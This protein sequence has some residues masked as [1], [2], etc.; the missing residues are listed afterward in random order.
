MTEFSVAI[1]DWLRD[2]ANGPEISGEMTQF[3][4]FK[5]GFIAGLQDYSK[6]IL[7]FKRTKEFSPCSS[8]SRLGGEYFYIMAFI[9]IIIIA[10]IPIITIIIN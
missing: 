7:K 5:E 3:L 4:L 10:I 1:P 8:D 2:L 6:S 9:I